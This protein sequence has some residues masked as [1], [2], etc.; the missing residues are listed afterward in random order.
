[1]A[2]NIQ[3]APSKGMTLPFI[4]YGGSSMVALS[5]GF[6]LLLAFTRRNP[7]LKRSPYVG[8]VEQRDE[9]R[10]AISFSPPAAPAGT[11]CPPH[12][13]AA[14]LM[15]RGHRVALVTDER[16]A[17]FPGLF[18]DVQTHVLPAG[19]LRRRR[20]SAGSGRRRSILAGRGDGAA[21]VRELPAGRGDRLRRLSGAAGAARRVRA[22]ACRPRS[23]SR[24]PCWAGSTGCVARRV[25]AIATA[26]AAVERLPPSMPSQGRIWSAIR[27]A[28]RCS[29]LRDQPYPPLD[30][31]GIFRVL[32]TGGSQGATSP[33]RRGARRAG[34]AAGR[35]SAAG[36]R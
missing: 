33:V 3:L 9:H 21:A 27:C 13:L 26:Y 29:R 17:R 24:M 1:M 20:R 8:D 32:V 11:W 4:S 22:T 25:D 12:A 18:E 15:R 14:E 6:G 19:R 16:G 30:E 10:A 34:A 31:D 7:Y 28:R 2:V 5:I 36:C 35:I 23:T